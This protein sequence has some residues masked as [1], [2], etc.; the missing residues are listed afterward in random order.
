MGFKKKKNY[1]LKILNFNKICDVAE[2][3]IIHK[4]I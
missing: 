1:F 2:V 3:A 4:V